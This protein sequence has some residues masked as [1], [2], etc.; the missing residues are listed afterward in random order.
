M[1]CELLT[2]SFC[3]DY[4]TLQTLL[5]RGVS[6]DSIVNGESALTISSRQG[7]VNCLNLLLD[8]KANP[9]FMNG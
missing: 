3:G 9:N 4:D 1:A 8:Y 2:A 6:A 5:K 7:D